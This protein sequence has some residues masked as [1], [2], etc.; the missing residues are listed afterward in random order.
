M[1]ELD[2]TGLSIRCLF[3][4]Y[5]LNCLVVSLLLIQVNDFLLQA[6]YQICVL[7]VLNYHGESILQLGNE[8]KE[9]AVDIKNTMVFNAFVL[10]Q[11]SRDTKF[12]PPA[13]ISTK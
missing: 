3:W 9:H 7:L 1:E 8:T 2:D 13:H 4:R 12:A 11:V 10:G 5:L 6:A